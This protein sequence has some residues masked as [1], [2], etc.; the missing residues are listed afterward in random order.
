MKRG[1]V[2]KGLK[3]Y[4]WV[5]GHGLVIEI[6]FGGWVTRCWNESTI[7]LTFNWIVQVLKLTNVTI[8]VHC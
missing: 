7:I 8:V 4:G 5:M 3:H 2:E 1:K 6:T